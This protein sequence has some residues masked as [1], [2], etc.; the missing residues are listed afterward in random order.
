MPGIDHQ[1][2]GRE[3]DAWTTGHSNEV[4]KRQSTTHVKTVLRKSR[5]TRS[6]PTARIP[7]RTL[8]T[9]SSAESSELPVEN[10]SHTC[11]L[12]LAYIQ[13]QGLLVPYVSQ[14]IS[15]HNKYN[16][17]IYNMYSVMIERGFHTKLTNT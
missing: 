2:F 14:L 7:T 8:I 15:I 6:I 11:S 16:T 5:V 3:Q 1:P 12:T 4:M 10:K 17:V 13:V 9:H